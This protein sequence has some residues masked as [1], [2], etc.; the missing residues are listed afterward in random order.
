MMRVATFILFLAGARDVTMIFTP[1]RLQTNL[2]V[3]VSLVV[4]WLRLYQ[5]RD[6][7]NPT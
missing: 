3:G 7:R 4:C 6:Q 5:G 2:M 1:L